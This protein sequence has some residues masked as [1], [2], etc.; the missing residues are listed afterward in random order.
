MK[1]TIQITEE[2]AEEKDNNPGTHSENIQFHEYS[3]L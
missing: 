1:E 2:D 3:L